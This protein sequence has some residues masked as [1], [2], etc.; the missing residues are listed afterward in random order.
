[1]R[2]DEAIAQAAHQALVGGQG[3]VHRTSGSGRDSFAHR[4]RGRGN[5]PVGVSPWFVGSALKVRRRDDRVAPSSSCNVARGPGPGKE[6][7]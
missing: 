5:P 7:G 2:L 6:G 1:L 3:P 4:T